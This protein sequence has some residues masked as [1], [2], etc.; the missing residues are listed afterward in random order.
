VETPLNVDTGNV[1]VHVHDKHCA[2][3]AW[4]DVQVVD[5]KLA[6][7]RCERAIEVV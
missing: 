2:A 5:I 6:V 7:L 4:E 1:R 3:V